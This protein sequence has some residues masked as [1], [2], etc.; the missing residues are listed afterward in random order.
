MSIV[1][2]I[3]MSTTTTTAATSAASGSISRANSTDN[4]LSVE[5]DMSSEDA[6]AG[7]SGSSGLPARQQQSSKNVKHQSAA[8]RPL[9]TAPSFDQRPAPELGDTSPCWSS[10]ETSGCRSRKNSVNLLDC[11]A[12]SGSSGGVGGGGGGNNNNTLLAINRLGDV[13]IRTAP[14]S[15]S[16]V[17]STSAICGRAANLS[18]SVHSSRSLCE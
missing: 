2:C 16:S 14:P 7:T 1:I 8:A 17:D 18:L 9:L 13:A 10:T 6:A 11:L 12:I 3:V 5:A 15:Q 4:L